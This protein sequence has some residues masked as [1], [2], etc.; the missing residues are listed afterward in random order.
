MG[1]EVAAMIVCNDSTERHELEAPK[2]AVVNR[3]P[4]LGLALVLNV[5][6]PAGKVGDV[7]ARAT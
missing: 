7:R 6:K 5:A 1:A 2:E 3:Q 4:V